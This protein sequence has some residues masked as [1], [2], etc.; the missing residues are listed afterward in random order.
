MGAARRLALLGGA[1]IV[2]A[3]VWWRRNPSACPYSQRFWVEAPHPFIT[4]E[5]LREILEPEPGER[6]LELGP[7]T[8]YYTLPVA[9]WLAPNGS[10]DVLDVQQEMLDHTL[11]RA[12]EQGL[13]NITPTLADARELPY[14]DDSFDGAY[15]V[16]VLGEIPDQ[17]AAL[18]EL[19]RVVKPG[20]RVVVGELFGDPHMVTHS[21]LAERARKAGLSVERRLGGALWH[22]TRLQA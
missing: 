6:L 17:D 10:L 14:E 18:R 15:L 20:G 4:R 1:A 3:A 2:G 22:F 13:D 9:G 11:R 19:R 8:G 5:R 21:A 16:T 12:R 7:G